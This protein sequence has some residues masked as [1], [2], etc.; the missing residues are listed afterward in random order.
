VLTVFF[1]SAFATI[2]F[3]GEMDRRIEKLPIGI[4]THS[5]ILE[6]AISFEKKLIR[7][8]VWSNF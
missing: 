7:H 4:S 1:D 6:L 5:T 8:H 2:W 3:D